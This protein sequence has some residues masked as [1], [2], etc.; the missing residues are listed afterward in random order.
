MDRHPA[1][2]VLGTTDDVT[3][4]DCCGRA[5]LRKTIAL[6]FDGAV[7]PVYYGVTCAAHALRRSVMEVR[8][9]VK[10]ADD[11]ARA[12]RREAEAVAWRAEDERWGAWLAANAPGLG[13]RLD[14]IE[15]L[16]GFSAARARYTA[17]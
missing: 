3:T 14:Q 12:A 9:S 1:A 10:A 13:E 6:A 11:A 4:C 17:E 15:A 2:K 8:S 5:D 16:G 7:D